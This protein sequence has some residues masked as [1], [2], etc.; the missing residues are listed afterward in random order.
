MFVYIHL[1][2]Y[3]FSTIKTFWLLFVNAVC[4]FSCWFQNEGTGH[5]KVLYRW[6]RGFLQCVTTLTTHSPGF[7]WTRQPR[8]LKLETKLRQSPPATLQWLRYHKYIESTTR[9]KLVLWVLF[10]PSCLG[11]NC[12]LFFNYSSQNALG[13]VNKK[14]NIAIVKQWLKLQATTWAQSYLTTVH[15]SQTVPLTAA[16]PAVTS[17]CL[18]CSSGCTDNCHWITETLEET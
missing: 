10:P 14:C 12:P 8:G 9:K 6:L 17:S 15:I 16:E 13:H 1:F 7:Q 4:H 18:Q 3:W 5:V 11:D 2:L